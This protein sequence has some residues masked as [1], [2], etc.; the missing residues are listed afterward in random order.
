MTSKPRGDTRHT[1]LSYL[2][3]HIPHA[4]QEKQRW[5]PQHAPAPK[6]STERMGRGVSLAIRP[7]MALVENRTLVRIPAAAASAQGVG[8]AA[9]V[10]AAPCGRCDVARRGAACGGLVQR[11]VHGAA[12]C[13]TLARTAWHHDPHHTCAR[14]QPRR[15]ATAATKVDGE[16]DDSGGALERRWQKW[17]GSEV[18]A[19]SAVAA[20]GAAASRRRRGDGGGGDGR[21][22]RAVSIALGASTAAA[23]LA[24][25]TAGFVAELLWR[26]RRR[27]RRGRLGRRW[28]RAERRAV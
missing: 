22:A 25:V 18:S 20:A 13:A 21:G 17:R 12:A 14:L 16:C 10:W 4:T 24:A 23:D 6:Q 28:R 2:E 27:R 5:L 3:I 19:G 1:P 9:A 11:H 7:A 8:R 15:P 26:R